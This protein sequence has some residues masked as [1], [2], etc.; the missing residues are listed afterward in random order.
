LRIWK[1]GDKITMKKIT[2]FSG[3]L[4]LLLA[5][6]CDDFIGNNRVI[7]FQELLDF[8][9]EVSIYPGVQ[10]INVG[11]ELSAEYDGPEDVKLAY[12]WYRNEIEIEGATGRKFT[13]FDVGEYYVTIN[14]QG[15]RKDKPSASVMVIIISVNFQGD[16]E[17]QPDFDVKVGDELTAVYDGFDI[18]YIES[19]QWYRDG[20]IIDGAVGE[21]YTADAAGQYM[22]VIS[23]QGFN[24]MYSLEVTVT[25]D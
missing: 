25:D 21:V 6:G 5:V 8:A 20:D 18:D 14:A 9:G 24:S 23:G 12:Q 15:Y 19:Y 13:P 2:L 7:K 1:F 16:L 22:V 17:I 3:F 10:N 11:I 4:A